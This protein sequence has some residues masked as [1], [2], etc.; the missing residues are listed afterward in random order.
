MKILM[1]NQPPFN[2]GDESA[3][4][5][6]VRTLL[7]RIPNLQ[8]KVM[9]IPDY[10][11]SVRQF[12]IH[13][14]RVEY[15]EDPA[16]V[17]RFN[18]FHW[19]G[20]QKDRTWLWFFHPTMREYKKIYEWADLVMCAPG[21]ICMGGF[22][23]WDHLFRLRLAQ[24]FHKPLAY[25][26]RSF[27]PFPTESVKQRQFKKLSLNLLNDFCFLSIRDKKS[28]QLAQELGVKYVTTVDSAFLDA[29]APEIPY[30]L[31]WAIADKPYMVFVPNYLRWHYA[32]R[33]RLSHETVID[34]YLA[35]MD[36]IW[37]ANP[38]LNIVM[39]PQVFCGNGY[40][41]SDVELFRDLATRK[42][43]KRVIVASD[44]YSSDIQQRIIAGAKYVIGARYHSVVFALNQA[45][46]CIALS[47]EH[48][49]RGLLET[50]DK[51]E[52]CIDF[53]HSLDT[54]ESRKEC[55]DR[56]SAMIPTLQPDVAAQQKAK[57][58]AQQ[59]MDEFIKTCCR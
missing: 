2:R 27:G 15:I 52:W 28:E 14:N 53:D 38:E 6:L 49:M 47:Y 31:K 20:M 12:A 44:G 56:V 57:A 40:T 30:E 9:T 1:I 34:F 59:C 43:D 51:T 32:Y 24:V 7:Q 3:H 48:K 37:A 22:Q 21:G 50:L 18:T 4:K 55:L 41:F 13:D 36:R 10:R 8:L 5:A 19:H 58:I 45:V 46:P 17:M 54:E 42:C 29:P 39:L 16:P 33:D 26:G 23:D 11:E 35:M 25:Y